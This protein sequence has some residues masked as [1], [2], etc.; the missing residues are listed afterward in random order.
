MKRANFHSYFFFF[1]QE[2]ITF[3]ILSDVFLPVSLLILIMVWGYQLNAM[4]LDNDGG[5]DQADRLTLL[6]YG[7]GLIVISGSACV[8]VAMRMSAMRPEKTAIFLP[9]EVRDHAV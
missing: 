2:Q 8:Y 5:D 4:T 3:S 7:I 9:R 6:L 1:T